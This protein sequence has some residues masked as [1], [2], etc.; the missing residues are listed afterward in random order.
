V[1]SSK[2]LGKAGVSLA[3]V[4]DVQGSIA[5]IDTLDSEE[6]K[7]VHEMGTTIFS[8]RYAGDIRR[9]TTG[10]IAQNTNASAFITNLP[11][12]PFRIQAI[13]V[14]N[15]VLNSVARINNLG[16][17]VRDPDNGTEVLVWAWDGTINRQFMSDEGAAAAVVEALP[18]LTS[19]YSI[20]LTMIG[21]N[22]PETVRDIAIRISTLGFGAGTVEAV[23][24][25]YLSFNQVAGLSS[26]G[27]PVP[28][29]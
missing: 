20:P 6:V 22:Q 4:Y 8:E 28:G 23:A 9:V 13:S 12:G 27:L 16:I 21:V 24:L 15:P 18:P 3:D 5:G 17:Y 1:P 10:D 29:W 7:T 19:I 2:I 14:F 11:A 25:I 26:F